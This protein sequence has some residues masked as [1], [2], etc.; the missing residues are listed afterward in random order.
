MNK[1]QEDTRLCTLESTCCG[2]LRQT[3]QRTR[4]TSFLRVQNPLGHDIPTRLH[5]VPY[6]GHQQTSYSTTTMWPFTVFLWM[7]CSLMQLRVKKIWALQ[8]CNDRLVVSC[9]TQSMKKQQ[10]PQKCRNR[11]QQWNFGIK[12]R[13]KK[14]D[15]AVC[16]LC[17]FNWGIRKKTPACTEK[18]SRLKQKA[19]WEQNMEIF[20]LKN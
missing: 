1:A 13:K 20:E 18:I 15:M 17:H 9:Y 8:L 3:V 10:L 4:N 7:I 19:D 16:F 12:T 5:A 14:E 2:W 6:I 11:V